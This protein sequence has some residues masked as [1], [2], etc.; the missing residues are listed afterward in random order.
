MIFQKDLIKKIL[1]GT[2]TMTR[3][4]FRS[5]DRYRI[6]RTYTVQPG[7]G[8]HGLFKIKVTNLKFEWLGDITSEDIKAEGYNTKEEFVEAW[9][10]F[11]KN[12]NPRQAVTVIKF[13]V[14]EA[15]T[16]S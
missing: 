16:S 1:N 3:R 14:E 15:P 10:R 6:G 12:Y 13:E 7:R 2:K 4:S 9:K 5:R 11:N 8:K